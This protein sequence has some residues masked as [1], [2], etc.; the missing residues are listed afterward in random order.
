[1]EINNQYDFATG[2]GMFLQTKGLPSYGSW[3]G[4][5]PASIQREYFGC[6]LGRGTI[7]VNG[8]DEAVEA[9]R[10]VCFGTDTTTIAFVN[11]KQPSE[12]FCNDQGRTEVIDLITR[13][14]A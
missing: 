8:T 9:V 7:H 5:I 10:K 11:A 4:T 12:S 6:F 2:I 13:L 1:M 14:N 3:S